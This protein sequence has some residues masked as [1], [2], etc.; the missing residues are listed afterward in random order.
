MFP[1]LLRSLDPQRAIAYSEMGGMIRLVWAADEYSGIILYVQDLPYILLISAIFLRLGEKKTSVW[2]LVFVILV[3]LSTVVILKSGGRGSLIVNGFLILSFYH[4]YVKPLRLPLLLLAAVPLY[5]VGVTIPH[6]RSVTDLQTMF[7]HAI[8]LISDNPDFLLLNNVGELAAP[9]G[10]LLILVDGI[11]GGAENY[12]WGYSIL[13]EFATFIPRFLFSGRPLTLPEQF[14]QKFLSDLYWSGK[15]AGFFILMEGYWT[16]GIIGVLL[17][18]IVWG[19]V[20]GAMYSVFKRNM[21]RRPALLLYS[22]IYPTVVVF[23][24]RTGLIGSLKSALMTAA[25]IVL[26]MLCLSLV[27]PSKG[28]S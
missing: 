5:L 21:R 6:V 16:L 23:S 14:T 11:K 2:N 8:S 4:Y 19:A 12:T 24:V 25:P 15:G 7:L 20:V 27:R 28:S 13:T 26:V 1:D 17:E 22:L 3:V 9:S 10:N 18:M